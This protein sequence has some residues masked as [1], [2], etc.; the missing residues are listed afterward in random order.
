MVSEKILITA[1]LLVG[2]LLLSIVMGL[3]ILGVKS[4]QGAP[5]G[6]LDSQ[7]SVCSPAPNCVCSE[8]YRDASHFVAPLSI[9][10]L[11]TEN[12]MSWSVQALVQMGAEVTL[13]D[14][15]YLSAEFKSRLFGFV[16]DFEL[17][18]DSESGV[19]H[20]RSSSRVGYSDFGANSS[21]VRRFIQAWQ[22]L[23]AI[24]SD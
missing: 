3:L 23:A 8:F 24:Q 13:H 5:Q 1:A 11:Q 6:L 19:L 15:H 16:D 7:L 17:R 18:L 21:R 10:P 12:V 14:Q 20:F 4:R 9:T 22:Q 2:F